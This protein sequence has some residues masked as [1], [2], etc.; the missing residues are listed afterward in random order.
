VFPHEPW[1]RL[2]RERG[3]TFWSCEATRRQAPTA[4][5]APEC[6][7]SGPCPS[8]GA[9]SPRANSSGTGWSTSRS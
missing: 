6:S 9:S 1:L 3:G 8:S 7:S 5:G 2:C 4:P